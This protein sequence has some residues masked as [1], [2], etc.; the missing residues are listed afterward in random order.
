MTTPD[1]FEERANKLIQKAKAIRDAK[2]PEYSH[3][4]GDYHG[5]FRK[6]ADLST[7]DIMEVWL[8][9]MAKHYAAIQSYVNNPDAKR[10]EPM[11]ERFADIINFTLFGYSLFKERED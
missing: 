1:Q 3:G 8:I 2:N 6:Q 10:S 7:G 11:D 5:F 4:N 9:M